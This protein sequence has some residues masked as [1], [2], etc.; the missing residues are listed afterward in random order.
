MLRGVLA[1]RIVAT[2]DVTARQAESEVYPLAAHLQT[3]LTPLR[4]SRRDVV[5]LIEMRALI[6]FHMPLAKAGLLRE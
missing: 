6:G 2:A 1:G 3:F 4:R 5:Y